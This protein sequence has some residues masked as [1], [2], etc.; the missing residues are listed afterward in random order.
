[1]VAA[2]GGAG[3][4]LGTNVGGAMGGASRGAQS[5]VCWR[6]LP[7]APATGAIAESSGYHS[8]CKGDLPLPERATN[9]D[10]LIMALRQEEVAPLVL[11]SCELAELHDAVSTPEGAEALAELDVQ[12]RAVQRRRALC[13]SACCAFWRR[14][15]ARPEGCSTP[16]S[17]GGKQRRSLA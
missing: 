1:M 6:C 14:Q 5:A 12:V 10:D 8:A 13:R 16:S 4:D 3:A 15:R 9:G 17:R 11:S 7:P 2:V